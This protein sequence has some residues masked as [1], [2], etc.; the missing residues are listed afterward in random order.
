[1]R[2]VGTL[3]DIQ[4]TRQA[5]D[6]ER[7]LLESE[8]RRRQALDINEQIVRGLRRA[9]GSLKDG[10]AVSAQEA[11]EETHRAALDMVTDLIHPVR[12]RGLSLDVGDILVPGAV[13]DL[14]RPNVS[15]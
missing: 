5:Q 1:L 13:L 14:R 9:A 11:I 6:T 7:G 2:L 10:D 3:T 12:E 15:N 8:I 4:S